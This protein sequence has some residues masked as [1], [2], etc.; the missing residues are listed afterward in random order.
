[1]QIY[2]WNVQHVDIKS[3]SCDVVRSVGPVY[4]FLWHS[5]R[6]STN[7]NRCYNIQSNESRVE[8]TREIP[9]AIVR[10][11]NGIK[12]KWLHTCSKGSV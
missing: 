8:E 2:E 11:M 10:S 12:I 4:A 1:M 3:I 7:E 5:I 6:E 9:S